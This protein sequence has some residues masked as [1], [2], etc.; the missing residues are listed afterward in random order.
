VIVDATY[1]RARDRRELRAR[2]EP[3]GVPVRFVEC[4]APRELRLERA[5]RRAA[6]PSVSD[7]D[8][9]VSSRLEAEF[10]PLDELPP[11]IHARV[12]TDRPTATAV[13]AVEAALDERWRSSGAA[14]RGPAPPE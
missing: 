13:T 8:Q 7:A 3:L 5:A 1:R 12:R 9:R 2:L 10:E 6:S 11:A 4:V 14:R